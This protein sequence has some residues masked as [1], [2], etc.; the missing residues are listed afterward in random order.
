MGSEKEG[1]KPQE[2]LGNFTKGT[3]WGIVPV[4]MNL[5]FKGAGAWKEDR[6][7]ENP[8]PYPWRIRQ[9]KEETGVVPLARALEALDMTEV[10]KKLEEDYFTIDRET[11]ELIR[12]KLNAY[13]QF[14]SAVNNIILGHNTISQAIVIGK[15]E[16]PIR[17]V[18]FD[19]KYLHRLNILRSL[20]PNSYEAKLVAYAILAH[21]GKPVGEEVMDLAREVLPEEFHKKLEEIKEKGGLEA[22]ALVAGAYAHV[23]GPSTRSSWHSRSTIPSVY[24]FLGGEVYDIISKARAHFEYIVPSIKIGDRRVV[25]LLEPVAKF[26]ETVAEI[27]LKESAD[28]EKLAEALDKTRE[29][30]AKV[31]SSVYPKEDTLL[32]RRGFLRWIG[33]KTFARAYPASV[34]AAFGAML[35]ASD[36]INRREALKYMAGAGAGI[37]LGSII[38]LYDTLELFGKLEENFERKIKTGGIEGVKKEELEEVE[39]LMNEINKKIAELQELQNTTEKDKMGVEVSVI[40]GEN[41][42][43]VIMY[44][45]SPRLPGGRETVGINLN[46]INKGLE[47]IKSGVEIL[48][49]LERNLETGEIGRK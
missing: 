32:G 29:T 10:V 7:V 15:K 35:M 43:D 11:F 30:L 21:M 1:E 17:E 13:K 33:S 16:G 12:R 20:Q 38:P 41:S 18:T 4:I 46:S 25:L 23:K 45:Y 9:I 40:L 26:L 27:P 3:L 6:E 2:D 49:E 44:H 39:R 24:D 22:V 19:R 42:A 28:K 47:Q 48:K 8:P 37:M 36:K 34:V 5:A 31:D 14:T